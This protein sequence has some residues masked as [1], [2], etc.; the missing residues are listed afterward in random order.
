M[1]FFLPSTVR[2][3]DKSDLIDQIVK[4]A[5]RCHPGNPAATPPPPP[6]EC[7][8]ELTELHNRALKLDMYYDDVMNALP[9]DRGPP[10]IWP[11]P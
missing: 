9:K 10:I 5:N 4:Y 1:G 3:D 6:P 11:H 8:N 7:D 2:A